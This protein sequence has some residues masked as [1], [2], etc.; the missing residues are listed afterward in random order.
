MKL[1]WS[2][3]CILPRWRYDIEYQIFFFIRLLLVWKGFV[4]LLK[5]IYGL[6]K[7]MHTKFDRR[8]VIW[9]LLSSSVEYILLSKCSI[10]PVI[11][12]KWHIICTKMQLFWYSWWFYATGWMKWKKIFQT[13][14]I[15][16]SYFQKNTKYVTSACSRRR[17]IHA[18]SM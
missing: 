13:E 16:P 3:L 8:Q 1:D 18:N 6:N 5:C 9:D 12:E 10:L 17:F 4:C 7:R 11:N 15:F 2:N 14:E